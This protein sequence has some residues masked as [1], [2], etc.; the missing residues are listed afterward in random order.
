MKIVAGSYERFLWGWQVKQKSE[1]LQPAFS[2]PAHLG[3]IKCI[4]ASGGVLVT[5]SSDDTIKV[6]DLHAHRDMG[7]LSAHKSAVTCLK[8]YVPET[9]IDH[10]THLFSGSEDASICIWDT[11]S[12]VRL[13]S[14]KAKA[15]MN[16]L[17]IH[18]SGRLALS[19]ERDGHF[20]MWNLIKGRCSFTTKLP[21]EATIINFCPKKGDTYAMAKGQVVETYNAE[22]GH[23]HQS[24][25]HL[26]HVLCM[27][28]DKDGV[29]FTGGEDCTISGWDLGSGKLAFEIPNAHSSRIKG[30]AFLGKANSSNDGGYAFASASSDGFVRV[31]D[32]RMMQDKETQNKRTPL[33]EAETKARL[34]CLVS[35][36]TL[37]TR[38]K[39]EEVDIPQDGSQEGRLSLEDIKTKLLE[40]KTAVNSQKLDTEDRK[41]PLE[42]GN[43]DNTTSA[44]YGPI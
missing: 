32:I 41:N 26:K 42:F 25:V 35:S 22:D 3:P 2:Y 14:M 11:D 43:M 7:S 21:N 39:P 19:V 10:A 38:I 9:G 33:M 15:A 28:T 23:L 1:K 8:F 40:K 44:M 13:K 24:F 36:G 30:L 31:W 18:P 5:G 16:D 27:A 37:K 17:A 4:A 20:R 29:L 6:F 12:W 34:T